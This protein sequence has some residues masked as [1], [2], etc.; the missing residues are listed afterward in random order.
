MQARRSSSQLLIVINADDLDGSLCFLVLLLLLGQDSLVSFVFDDGLVDG[1][2]SRMGKEVSVLPSP[3]R[4]VGT[5][6]E[7]GNED[8]NGNDSEGSSPGLLERRKRKGLR[9][10]AVEVEKTRKNNA[11]HAGSEASLV[12]SLVQ[13]D[14]DCVS[15][16]SSHVTPT[17]DES[18]CGSDDGSVKEAGRPGETGHKGRSEDCK[19]IAEEKNACQLTSGEIE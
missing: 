4:V 7:R 1:R 16:S 14:H 2:G 6:D 12:E 13:S 3:G 8:G 10:A 11:T 5:K 17:A 18:I 15:N 19:Q 9:S